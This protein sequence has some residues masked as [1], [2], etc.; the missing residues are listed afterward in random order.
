MPYLRL[1]GAVLGVEAFE[2][3]VSAAVTSAAFLAGPSSTCIASQ[4]THAHASC[5]TEGAV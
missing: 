4:S 2:P 1:G 3:G 5:D